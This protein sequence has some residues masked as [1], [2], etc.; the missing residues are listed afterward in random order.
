MA[1]RPWWNANAWNS[2]KI[3][4][5]ERPFFLDPECMQFA[6]RTSLTNLA[7]RQVVVVP[8]VVPAQKAAAVVIIISRD[9]LAG[10]V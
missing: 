9:T 6:L 5:T 1:P 3:P 2:L 4:L 10:P 7:F 8:A